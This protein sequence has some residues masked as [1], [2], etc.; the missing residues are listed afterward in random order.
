[1]GTEESE[2]QDGWMPE[3][4]LA[5]CFDVAVIWDGSSSFQVHFLK[6]LSAN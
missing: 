2:W 6:I 1:M 3:C 4:R 5:S